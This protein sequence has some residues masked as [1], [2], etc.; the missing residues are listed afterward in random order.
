MI[1]ILSAQ[2]AGSLVHV[3]RMHCRNLWPMNRVEQVYSSKN[4]KH[5]SVKSK[6][7]LMLAEESKNT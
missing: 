3:D 6:Q 7:T 5:V 4:L 2:C 1:T